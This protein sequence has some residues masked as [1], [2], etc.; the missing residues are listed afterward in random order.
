M[1]KIALL[2]DLMSTRIA[3]LDG[4]MGTMLQRQKLTA[5]DFGGAEYEG[6][7][8]NLLLT[9]PEAIA[10]VHRAYYAAGADIVETCTFGSTPIVLEDYGLGAKAYGISKAGAAVAAAEANAAQARDG[11]PRFV[12]GSMGPTT[13]SLSLTGG[14]TFEELVDSFRAQAG[15]LWDGG[16]DFLL[17]ETQL[18][19]LNTK[20]GIVG[21]ERAARERGVRIPVSI[22]GTVEMQGVLL[23]GQSAEAF[24][25]SLEHIDP[26]YVGLNCATGPEFM[27]DHV[28]SLARS[29]RTNVAC[30]PNAGLPNEHGGYDETPDMLARQLERFAE[31]GWINIVG[32]CCGTTPEHIMAVVQ[33][34]EGKKPRRI[35]SERKRWVTGIDLLEMEEAGRP[36]I[37]GERTNSIGSRAFKTLINEG[38]FEEAAEIARKQS[39]AGAHIIDVC[40]ANPDRDEKSDVVEFLTKAVKIVKAP[41]MIDSQDPNVVEA[42]FQLVQGKCVLNS[43]NLEDGPDAERFTGLLTLVKR[44]G[45][46]VVAGVIDEVGMAVEPERK[47]A[48][49]ERLHK[50]LTE[51]WGIAEEDIMF[52]ALV[53]PAGT[54]DENYVGSGAKTIE[55][56]RLISERFPRC[57][58]TLGVSNV[59]FGLPP[60][61]REVLNSV[62]LYHTT[63]AGLTSAIVNAE[64]LV[65]YAQIPQEEKDLCDDLIWNRTPDAVAAFTAH[66]RGK[67]VEEKAAAADL[68]PAQA[69]SN[70]V[71][72]GSKEGLTDN[73]EKLLVQ[74]MNPLEVI[75]GPL[76]DG[77]NEVGRLFNRNE[78]IVAEVLQSAEAMKAAVAY[79]EPRM[80]KNESSN[81]GVLMLATVK[82]DVHDIGKNLVEI[83]VGNNGYKVVNLGI[84]VPPDRLVAMAREHNPDLIGLSGLLV[85]SA[86]EMVTAARDLRDAGIHTPILVGGAALSNNFTVKNIASQYQGAVVYCKDAMTGLDAA[87]KLSGDDSREP[88]LASHR[89]MEEK[90][91]T[92]ADS[93]PSEAPEATPKEKL[94]LVRDNE[95][96]VPPTL[97]RVEWTR[98][99]PEIWKYLNPAM[100]FGK[101]LGLKGSVERLWE[102]KD[103]K[104]LELRDFVDSL[105]AESLKRGWIQPGGVYQFFRAQ[106]DGDTIRLLAPDGKSEAGSFRFP[107]QSDGWGISLSDFVHPRK[108]DH[109][110]MFCVTS[111]GGVRAA[112]EELK[113]KGEYLKAHALAALALETAEAMAELC[114]RHLRL[115][116]GFA[117]PADLSVS[118]IFKAKYRGIRVSFGYPACPRLEDQE[119]LFRLL[120]PES[121][122][123]NLTE[124]CMM[125]PEGSV[126]ALV[127]HHPQARYF[128]ISPKDLDAFEA[129]LRG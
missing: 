89:S 65:R 45:A 34:V 57:Q 52:D 60:A 116:W 113:A 108:P 36:Y 93:K 127:F 82:G 58:S 102:E 3:V 41:F 51:D 44:Y 31:A 76:M 125:D 9:K 49:A 7:N 27:T 37:V 38:K 61:G 15:G 17:L 98:A 121:V 109:V 84:K 47:L 83:I 124:G 42:A 88:F 118:D 25:A 53:F 114:H 33:A 80:E 111:G 10:S 12:A 95:L 104:A 78:L 100:L 96:F 29:A 43:V 62:F 4:G 23:G 64:K 48:V 74:G 66:F 75:N 59:S 128:T 71:L 99:L 6:C 32:G 92:G 5:A 55:G 69:V 117:D 28:R 81:R 8:E 21:I 2:K 14:A 40:L 56:V 115:S 90:V 126:S 85:K 54:G 86:H 1:S 13:K 46:M 105:K 107:R 63:K 22:S 77:M 112:V 16:S 39:R 123:V 67:K 18:D 30:A 26:F 97:E 103:P 94:V 106:A 11:K 120:R 122:G 68:P 72:T 20:A 110:A 87:N 129:T 19:T 91:R 35:P 119:I 73:L 24:Y 101:H 70:C 50:I 79:L